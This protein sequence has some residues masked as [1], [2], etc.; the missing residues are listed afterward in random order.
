LEELVITGNTLVMK[1]PEPAP[2]SVIDFDKDGKEIISLM[3]DA[4][5]QAS[6]NSIERF[7]PISRYNGQKNDIFC[8]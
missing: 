3:T 5:I 7:I 6:L 2:A 1:K 8:S 4:A